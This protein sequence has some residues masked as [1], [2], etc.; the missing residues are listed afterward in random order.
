MHVDFN[1][2]A[3]T[4][5]GLEQLRPERIAAF[6]NAALAVHAHGESLDFGALLENRCQAVAAI[7][8][9]HLGIHALDAVIGVGAV[10]PHVGVRPDAELEMQPALAGLGRN[11]LQHFEVLV[12]LLPGQWNWIGKQ[13]A[14]RLCELDD[15]HTFVA[16]NVKE[17]RVREV[18]VVAGNVARTVV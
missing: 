5:D 16:G 6:W 4:G 12:L 8:G 11:E 9:V 14:I 7:G 13:W 3:A 15:T 17:V 18:E 2:A 1:G 10:L